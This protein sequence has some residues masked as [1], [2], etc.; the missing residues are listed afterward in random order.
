MSEDYNATRV[1]KLRDRSKI[2]KRLRRYARK[3]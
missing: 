1:V 2:A 3:N